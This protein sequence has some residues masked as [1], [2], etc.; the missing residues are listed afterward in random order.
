MDRAGKNTKTSAH[1]RNRR[2]PSGQVRLTL[3]SELGGALDGGW[4]PYTSAGA[5]ELPALIEAVGRPLGEIIDSGVNWSPLEGVPDLD[6][7]NYRGNA[8]VRSRNTRP[9]RVMPVTRRRACARLLV[10]ASRNTSAP[11]AM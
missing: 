5:K 10:A 9:Q 7:L 4:W 8:A 2:Q 11:P 1:E 6:S 3:V